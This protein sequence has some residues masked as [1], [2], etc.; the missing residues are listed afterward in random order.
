MTGASQWR[1]AAGWARRRALQAGAALTEARRR[2]DGLPPRR[3]RARVGAPGA[4]EFASGGAAAADALLAAAAEALGERSA[5]LAGVLDFGCG[6]GRVLGE[7]IRRGVGEHRVGVDVD[8]EAIAWAEAHLPGARWL[9]SSA[10]PPLPLVGERFDLIYSV[11]VFSH[12][13]AVAQDAWLTELAGTL[14]PGGVAL[15]SVHGAT[16]LEAFRSGA[17]ATAWCPPEALR[18]RGPLAA[19]EL[20][21]VPYVHSRW[22]RGDLPGVGAGY[23]LSFH[24]PEYLRAHWGRFLA[25]EAIL[26]RAI[27]GWQDLVVCRSRPPG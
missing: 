14:A 16:A 19:D 18:G 24:G 25:V 1:P 15:L 11:S 4:Q 20:W 12:L 6:S 17:V 9:A 10:N 27:S 26:P 7:M 23:G 5:A 8:A 22:N 2:P 13:D 21:S 3:L